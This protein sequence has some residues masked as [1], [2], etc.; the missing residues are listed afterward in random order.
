MV[1]ETRC[2]PRLSPLSLL[3]YRHVAKRGKAETLAEEAEEKPE[4]ETEPG[5]FAKANKLAAEFRGA[6]ASGQTTV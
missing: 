1:C 6:A 3:K 4:V 2:V 5:P